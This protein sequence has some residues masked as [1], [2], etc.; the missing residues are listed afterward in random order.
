MAGHVETME[1]VRLTKRADALRGE[2][3]RKEKRKTETRMGGLRE[4]RFGGSGREMENVGEGQGE[5][6]RVVET[7]VKRD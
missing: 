2:G 5:W 7:A 4:E 6:R 1:G 3:R